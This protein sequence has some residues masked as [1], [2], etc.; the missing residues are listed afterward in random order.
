MGLFGGVGEWCAGC[1]GGVLPVGLVGLPVAVLDGWQPVVCGGAG[2][3]CEAGH[4]RAVMGERDGEQR[5]LGGV[6]EGR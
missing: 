3:G 4:R 1:G 6:L 5:A 2:G